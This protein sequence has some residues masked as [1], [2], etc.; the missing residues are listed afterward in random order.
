MFSDVVKKKQ[1]EQHLK[2]IN[3]D[4]VAENVL[5]IEF[6]NL[7]GGKLPVWEPGAHIELKLGDYSRQYSLI[8]GRLN[9]DNWRIAVL[10][11]HDGRGGSLWIDQN[12]KVGTILS[13]V[14]PRN[15]FPLVRASEYNF[16]AG[17]I[18]ITP[19]LRMIE[20][21]ENSNADWALSY[22]G[23]SIKSMAYSEELKSKYGPKV[24]LFPKNEALFY[25]VSKALQEINSNSL[26][27]SCGPERLMLEME[28]SLESDGRNRLRLER[29]HPRE[30]IE[31]S[32]NVEF[33]VYC[34]KSKEEIVVAADESI[35][36]VADFAGI[37]IEGDCMEGTCGS[38]ETRVIEGEIEHRDS[39]LTPEARAKGDKMM[40]CV[41]RARGRIVLDL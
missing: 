5:E 4:F 11:E 14:G 18:G 3:R 7:D 38:C 29:F 9:Q 30:D 26:I 12:V 33:T 15:N 10:I 6:V 25:D 24:S 2:V 28:K 17:G 16:V 35:L 32:E 31:Q 27:Y 21:A 37:E 22:L 20:E 1:S 8:D 34:S 13:S 36:M 40:I 23:K 41:S 39:I 19:L